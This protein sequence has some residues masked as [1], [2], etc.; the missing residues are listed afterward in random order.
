MTTLDG[1]VVGTTKV[2]DHGPP[3]QRWNLVILGDGY[4]AADLSQYDA[5]VASFVKHLYATAPFGD[6]W[7]AINIYQVT[8]VSTDRGADDPGTCADGSK[9]TGPVA[10]YFD[11]SFCFDGNTRRVLFGNHVTALSVSQ[12]AVPPVH[13]TIVIANTPQYGGGGAPLFGVAWCST[14]PLAADIAIHELGHA[15]FTLED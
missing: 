9:G 11:S 5:D 10:T 2:L 15:Y 14:D 7:D 13:A 8:V 3:T 4:R 1:F 12:T 6:L